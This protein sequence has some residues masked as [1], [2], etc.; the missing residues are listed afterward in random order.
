MIPTA[1]CPRCHGERIDPST[2][3]LP[4]AEKQDCRRCGGWGELPVVQMHDI[5]LMHTG[6]KLS[7]RL[8][9]A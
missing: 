3:H 5:R 9:A 1:T 4:D 2:R 8:E 7:R 6:E